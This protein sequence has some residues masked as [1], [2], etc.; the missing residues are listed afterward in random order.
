MA[1]ACLGIEESKRTLS[2]DMRTGFAMG[3]LHGVTQS[4]RMQKQASKCGADAL[5]MLL[6]LT[7]EA[8]EV[9]SLGGYFD[10]RPAIEVAKALAKAEASKTHRGP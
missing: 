7:R 5:Y 2:P 8:D 3:F 10:M 9:W 4:R 1:K 6:E